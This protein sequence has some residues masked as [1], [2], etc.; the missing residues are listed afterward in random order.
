M[1]DLYDECID[2]V[3]TEVVYRINKQF[4]KDNPEH[5]VVKK[6]FTFTQGKHIRVR[7]STKPKTLPKD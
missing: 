3:S 6:W 5:P 4:A 7:R 2:L 1:A